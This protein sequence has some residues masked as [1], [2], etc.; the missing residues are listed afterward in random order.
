MRNKINRH[1]VNSAAAIFLAG[2]FL[3]LSVSARDICDSE[4][5]KAAQREISIKHESQFRQALTRMLCE[6]KFQTIQDAN[7]FGIT[8]DFLKMIGL[9]FDASGQFDSSRLNTFYQHL[10]SVK[11]DFASAQESFEF[12]ERSLDPR[13]VDVIRACRAY[14]PGSPP[15]CMPEFSSDVNNVRIL[16]VA[17]PAGEARRMPAQISVS[18][19]QLISQTATFIRKKQDWNFY[20]ENMRIGN[21][22]HLI[23]VARPEQFVQFIFSPREMDS[24]S[25]AVLPRPMANINVEYTVRYWK[26][27]TRTIAHPVV[28]FEGIGCDATRTIFEKKIPSPFQNSAELY[29]TPIK[30]TVG[31]LKADCKQEQQNVETILKEDNVVVRL[32]AKGCD[33]VEKEEIIRDRCPPDPCVV[34]V[35]LRPAFI[36]NQWP[37][38]CFR[39]TI[40]LVCPNKNTVEFRPYVTYMLKQLVTKKLQPLTSSISGYSTGSF[41]P[42]LTDLPT[43]SIERIDAL[44]TI[45]F[46]TGR[47]VSFQAADFAGHEGKIHKARKEGV[48]VYLDTGTGQ[49]DVI[50]ENRPLANVAPTNR[51]FLY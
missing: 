51:Y 13:I 9:P 42:D 31:S 23:T 39:K 33:P 29:V 27:E 32:H 44:I 22:Y 21:H 40:R 8:T 6:K 35:D 5:I 41:K 30:T 48:T 10:C 3:V 45:A 14:K 18:N 43:A 36:C 2:H 50:V 26:E 11:N 15:V 12:L 46:N 19:G 38:E 37:R 25:V 34:G 28:T 24:C 47:A 49:I 20:Q 17:I 16:T 4:L 7:R 1:A